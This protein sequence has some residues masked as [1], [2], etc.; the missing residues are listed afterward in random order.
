M[1]TEAIIQSA[2]VN[3]ADLLAF[4]EQHGVTAGNNR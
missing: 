1:T 4:K 2:A 3:C